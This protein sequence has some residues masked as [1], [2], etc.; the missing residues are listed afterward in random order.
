MY[1]DVYDILCDGECAKEAQIHV[2]PGEELEM[3][4]GL[5]ESARRSRGV[6]EIAVCHMVLAN[7]LEALVFLSCPTQ[8]SC[9]A[10]VV[11]CAVCAVW[12]PYSAAHWKPEYH[13]FLACL[14]KPWREL[15]R[16]MRSR[17]QPMPPQ[18]V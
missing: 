16:E 12:I 8:M 4:A 10:S 5:Y 6:C 2:A 11:A 18:A 17:S 9:V 7:S 15:G 13:E 3:E 1:E 14:R